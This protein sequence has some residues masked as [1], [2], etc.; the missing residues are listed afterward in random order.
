MIALDALEQM[1]AEPFELIGADARS[2][3]PRRP[4]P[5]RLSISPSAQSAAWSCGRPKHRKTLSCRR[6]QPQRRNAVHAYGR[7]AA[8]NCSAACARPAGLLNR[9]FPERQRLIGADDITAGIFR[10]HEAAP[11]RAPAAPRSRRARKG[12]NSSARR[13]RRYR[14][15]RPRRKCRHWQAAFAARGFARPGSADVFRARWSS[16]PRHSGSRCRCRSVN[17]FSTA[18]AVSSIERRVTSS[19]AQLNLALSFRA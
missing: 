8:R 11:S 4:R 2:S 1:H 9:R 14:R 15:E 5:D 13:V 10:R 18:A 19:C 7:Q 16:Y 17:S 3:R 12:R 6:A